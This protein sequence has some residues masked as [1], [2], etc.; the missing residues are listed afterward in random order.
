MGPLAPLAVGLA[1]DPVIVAVEVATI[2]RV[3][4]PHRGSSRCTGGVAVAEGTTSTD[5]SGHRGRPAGAVAVVITSA[6]IVVTA[7][8]VEAPWMR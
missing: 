8:G 5:R 6:P 4:A 3:A 2:S 1:A 7:L